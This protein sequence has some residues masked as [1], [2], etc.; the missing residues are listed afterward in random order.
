MWKFNIED[1]EFLKEQKRNKSSLWRN[2]LKDSDKGGFHELT[3]CK[4]HKIIFGKSDQNNPDQALLR[5]ETS[6]IPLAVHK[7]RALP[8][9]LTNREEE[10]WDFL[11]KWCNN[12][13]ANRINICEFDEQLG[14]K[15]YD[16]VIDVSGHGTSFKGFVAIPPL[17][18]IQS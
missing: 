16:T 15:L 18:W 8:P 10:V 13:A 1:D 9:I 5:R 2:N 11:I 4:E 7:S 17:E 14:Q 3:M 12:Q 6:Y